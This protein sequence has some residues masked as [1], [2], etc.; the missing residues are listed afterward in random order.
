MSS[1]TFIS[2]HSNHNLLGALRTSISS[3]GLFFFGLCS[4]KLGVH[5]PLV[6]LWTLSLL[7]LARKQALGYLI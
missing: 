6:F 1:F 4:P 2:I 5:Q 7:C 3:C